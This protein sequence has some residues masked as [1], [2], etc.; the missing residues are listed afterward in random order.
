[1]VGYSQCLA[2]S[3]RYPGTGSGYFTAGA[4][5]VDNL[6]NVY[7]TGLFEDQNGLLPNRLEVSRYDF[8]MNR[9]PMEPLNIASAFI[10]PPSAA[11]PDNCQALFV[12]GEYFAGSNKIYL[13]RY[14]DA[15]PAGSRWTSPSGGDVQGTSPVLTV[16]NYGYGYMAYIDPSN[17]LVV[18]KIFNNLGQVWIYPYPVNLT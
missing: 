8:C 15:Q 6:G 5:G 18:K 13:R 12:A 9:V 16:D 11:V 3:D 4:L 14:D 17:H 2:S 1:H 10:A 7:S